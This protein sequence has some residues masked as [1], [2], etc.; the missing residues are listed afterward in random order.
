MS[1]SDLILPDKFEVADHVP[2]LHEPSFW[3]PRKA[4]GE[5]SPDIEGAFLEGAAFARAEGLRTA[6][7]MITDGVANIMMLTDLEGDFREGG[8]LAVT[9]TNSAVLRVGSRLMNGLVTDHYTGLVYSQDSHPPNHISWGSSWNVLKGKERVPL[10]LREHKAV[11]LDLVDEQMGIFSATAFGPS[12]PIEVGYVQ[13]RFNV[14][15][16]VRYWQHLQDTNQGPIWLFAQHCSIGT[17]G[18][19]LHPLLA[20]VLSFATGARMIEPMPVFKGHIRDTDWFGPLEPCRPD[21]NHPQG[22][23][24]KPI[25]DFFES[26]TGDVEFA[27]VAEDFCEHNM[28]L[29]VMRYFEGTDF[30]NKMVFLLDCTAA[31]VPN[32]PHVLTLREEAKAKGVRF[33]THDAPL[34]A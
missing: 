15:D 16:S 32:A 13:R 27:G 20:E 12:G 28:E 17:D 34:A 18:T 26:A 11:I 19:N 3:D 29:Q 30:F 8:R 24:Q 2:L 9:G 6:Q 21:P 33:K 31:I 10:D 23:F 1:A 25:V 4:Y 14:K 5:F 7:Q 22:G